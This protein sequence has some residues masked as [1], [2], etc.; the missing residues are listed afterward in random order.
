[1]AFQIA[2]QTDDDA[3]KL[4]AAQL[5]RQRTLQGDS[6]WR[7]QKDLTPSA[8][9]KL[10]KGWDGRHQLHF[11]R[12]NSI[13]TLTCRDYFDRPREFPPETGAEIKN[14]RAIPTWTLGSEPAYKGAPMRMCT[15]CSDPVLRQLPVR[16][17]RCKPFSKTG[18]A[19]KPSA[20]ER[21]TST[22]AMKP[23][24]DGWDAR[25]ALLHS[26]ANSVYHESDK[27]Y[28]S[29]YL[30]PRSKRVVPKRV[31]GITQLLRPHKHPYGNADGADDPISLGETLLQPKS[32][33]PLPRVPGELLKKLGMATF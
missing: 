13:L 15:G 28:F 14:V 9:K 4:N 16:Y 31:N 22:P 5:E 25:H 19:P 24:E 10:E 17:E 11:S 1:M 8:R 18:P 26:A 3:P 23:R 33:L 2:G 20:L 6:F 27:E 32:E 12:N 7:N 29:M 30:Q 21:S